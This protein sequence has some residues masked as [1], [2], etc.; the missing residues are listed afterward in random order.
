LYEKWFHCK[1]LGVELIPLI[2]AFFASDE[3]RTKAPGANVVQESELPFKLNNTLIDQSK[4]GAYN[5]AEK[6]LENK[7]Q[8]SVCLTPQELNLQFGVDVL[9]QGEYE[10]EL[11]ENLNTWVWSLDGKSSIELITSEEKTESFTLGKHDSLLV[12]ENQ[13]KKLLVRLSGENSS[14]MR[15]TQN[16]NL[17]EKHH[18]N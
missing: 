14:L 8:N 7:N 3:Y 12:P 1:D 4:H 15:I 16:P 17:T 5:L 9:R 18:I 6:L 13:F 2:K 10:F 11:A